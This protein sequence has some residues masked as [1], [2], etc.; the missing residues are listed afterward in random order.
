[1]TRRRLWIYLALV[2]ATTALAIAALASLIW[3]SGGAARR[4]VA[5]WCQGQEP[6]PSRFQPVME[7]VG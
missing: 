3:R 7:Q 2:W 5:A 6:E 1:M 4:P